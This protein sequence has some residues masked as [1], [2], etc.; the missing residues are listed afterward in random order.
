MDTWKV[1]LERLA[2][3]VLHPAAQH[4]D[5][6]VDWAD[7][8]IP[9]VLILVVDV[10]HDLSKCGLAQPAAQQQVLRL[11]QCP[12]Q[13]I[14]NKGMRVVQVLF[15]HLVASSIPIDA[16][17]TYGVQFFPER[18]SELCLTTGAPP[19]IHIRHGE[20][21]H[22]AVAPEAARVQVPNARPRAVWQQ[23]HLR[24]HGVQP[25]P[26]EHPQ[27]CQP[28]LAPRGDPVGALTGM[29]PLAGRLTHGVLCRHSQQAS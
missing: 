23:P 6:L 17:I 2:V 22:A 25:I 4:V 12:P 15:G 5:D 18:L 21:H 24:G 19:A 26:R 13:D 29:D 3:G 27:H 14:L 11:V 20:V 9:G 28:E 7:V 8:H 10:L 16:V 1:P